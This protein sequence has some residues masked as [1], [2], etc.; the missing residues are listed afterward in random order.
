MTSKATATTLPSPDF[1]CDLAHG[2]TYV[3]GLRP[4][5]RDTYRLEP[6]RVAGK[7]LVHNYGHG[8][9]G[10]TMSWGCAD[11]VRNIVRQSY[12]PGPA[13]SVAVLGA[14]VMGLT[15][16]TLL[17]EAG[18]GVSIYAEALS[19]TTSEVAGGQW[20]PSIVDYEESN[21]T[22][23]ARFFD[24]LRTAY[25][26]HK[27]RLGSLYGVS[28]RLN[29]CLKPAEGLEKVAKAG[30]I[31][32]PQKL[33]LPFQYLSKPGLAYE[34]LLVEP[35]IFLEQLRRELRPH[36]PL[37]PKT[38]A[39]QQ[40]VLELAEPIVVNCTGLG[41]KRLFN[42]GKLKPIKGQLVLLRPQPSL[43]YLYSTDSTYVFPRADHVVVGGSFE[44]DEWDPAPNPARCRRIL[45]MAAD[46]FNGVAGAPAHEA[47]MLRNK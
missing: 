4:W 12:S 20:A 25:R 11:A 6:E 10:I 30:I 40:A 24:L 34:T 26:M 47:W 36:V 43:D 22:Q 42:D 5:R 2:C 18:F 31:P 27:A 29:Y 15:A 28:E 38:F 8:G 46:V 39:S 16:A 44:D 7:L 3:A 41:S 32:K 13:H 14:G 35:P 21:P 17:R 45:Q 23:A 1:A 19:G 33:K 37:I 9:A